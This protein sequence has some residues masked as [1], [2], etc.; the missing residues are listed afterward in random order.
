MAT[1]CDNCGATCD[2]DDLFCESCGY[3]FV[4][5]SVPESTD[6]PRLV[7]PDA[8]SGPDSD[9]DGG[10][11]DD[12][13]SDGGDSNEGGTKGTDTDTDT[14]GAAPESS[15]VPSL[16]DGS[17]GAI[18]RVLVAIS[19]DADYYA[20]MVTEGEVPLPDP[21]P[22]DHELELFGSELHIGRTSESRAVHPN[23]DIEA[24]TGDPAVSTRHAVLRVANDGTMTITDVGSTNG[25]FVDDFNG[26][27]V[28]QGIPV[29][30]TDDSV[31]FLGAWT[32]LAVK[33]G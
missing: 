25:T 20:A 30:L 10:E 19:T 21:R 16:V 13:D 26:E 4:T 9:S 15:P 17:S 33:P 22:P 23:I 18:P 14:D 32:R 24:L 2:P 1:T 31:V 28:T 3:D 12:G 7:D 5:G 27:P 8:G 29:G 6:L 11:F